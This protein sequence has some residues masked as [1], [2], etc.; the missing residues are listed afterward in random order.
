MEAK[1]IMSDIKTMIEKSLNRDASDRV[2]DLKGYTHTD[3]LRKG[4]QMQP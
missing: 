2:S 3:K 1:Q 4:K